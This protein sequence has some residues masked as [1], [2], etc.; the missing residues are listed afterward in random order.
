M[1]KR[2][3]T[4]WGKRVA[5]A[6]LVV[7]IVVTGLLVAPHSAESQSDRLVLAFYYAWYDP[8]S[9]GGGRTPYT[10]PNP[11]F[12]TDPATIQR[13][14]G[15]AKNAGIDGFVQ[16]W[17]GPDASQQTE[18]NFSTLLD[19]AAANGFYAAVDFEPFGFMNSNEDRIAAL[20]TLLATHAQ[21]PAYLRYNGKPVIFFW[22]N[23]LLSVDDWAYIRNAADP[24]YSSI[25]IAEGGHPQY[26]S[27]FDG[28]HL[29]NIAWSGNPAGTAATWA[30]TA[31]ANGGLWVATAMPGWNDTLL[32]RGDD[33]FAVDRAGGAFYRSTFSGAAASNPDMLII[34]SFNEW[35]EG[36]HIEPSAEFGSLYLD[37]TRELISA[38]KSGSIAAAPPPPA[39]PTNTPG[40]SPTPGPT[41][42]PT[43]TPTPIP[44]PTPL[45]DGRIVYEVQP[46]DT[47]LGIATRFEL[48]LPELYTLNDLGPDSLLSIGQ[49]IVVG[50]AAGSDVQLDESRA[51][52]APERYR[53]AQLND[54]G[55]YVHVVQTGDT[56]ISIAVQ[57]DLTLPDLYALSG[58]DETAL[59]SV[60]QQVV[61]G[62][63]A[64]AE[65]PLQATKESAESLIP[66][67]FADAVIREDGKFIHI[68]ADGDTLYSIAFQYDLTLDD[69]LS[70]SGLTETSLL[71]LGQEIVVGDIPQPALQG[72][73]TDAPDA[74]TPTPTVTVAP[75][76]TPTPSPSP[77]PVEPELPP[78][79]E[80]VAV[81]EAT[82]TPVPLIAQ[83]PDDAPDRQ[84]LL[85][86][87]LALF[88]S[89]IVLVGVGVYLIFGRNRA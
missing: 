63:Q 22:A 7:A 50:Y 71:Q 48:E 68:V 20:Q 52:V 23:W 39:L 2:S 69:L 36:S 61:V 35:P 64:G 44:S 41:A 74:P 87:F 55:A 57:Y 66:P 11:Y 42:T 59:L 56:L 60:G 51:N 43:Q 53:T 37:L 79:A 27:V 17:Y 65:P 8:S 58:L 72:G 16:S 54:D 29:Y 6:C 85:P 45:P 15:H 24:G 5:L 25:W 26:L 13:Q 4:P 80:A 86:A 73:S 28:L 30:G 18:P 49:Q 40:P 3:G 19:T 9:F 77:T 33:A 31:R 70:A 78:P 67:Q 10:N 82:A 47:L 32:G 14:V 12:S 89:A 1:Q 38:Y 46:G 76:L 21:H 84:S 75:T 62:W 83:Q 88:G 34:T 81:L